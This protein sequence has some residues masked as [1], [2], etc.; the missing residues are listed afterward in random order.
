MG[1]VRTA[2]ARAKMKNWLMLA[3]REQDANGLLRA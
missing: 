2:K 1:A 3:L